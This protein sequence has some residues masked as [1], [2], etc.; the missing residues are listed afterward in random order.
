MENLKFFWELT[1]PSKPSWTGGRTH[2]P[3]QMDQD[4]VDVWGDVI[5]PTPEV[6]S[7]TQTRVSSPR[8]NC[9]AALFDITACCRRRLHVSFDATSCQGT[10]SLSYLDSRHVSLGS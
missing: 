7:K 6:S 8:E 9:N 10:I 3:A 1:W 5:K 2:C 4:H